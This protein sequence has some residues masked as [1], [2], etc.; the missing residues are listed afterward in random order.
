VAIGFGLGHKY[1]KA[2]AEVAWLKGIPNPSAALSVIV[3]TGGGTGGGG[4]GSVGGV[5]AGGGGF[6][7]AR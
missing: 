3:A 6:S 2:G 4:T 5:A 1:S 7:G